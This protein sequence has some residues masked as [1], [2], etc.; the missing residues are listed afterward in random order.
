MSMR[1]I[2]GDSHPAL[3]ERLA[4]EVL[5]RRDERPLAPEWVV[6]PSGALARFLEAEL[7]ARTRKPLL[8]VTVLPLHL[9]AAQA[10]SARAEVPEGDAPG[11]LR[12]ALQRVLEARWGGH[13]VGGL[14]A[15]VAGGASVLSTTLDELLEAGLHDPG[16]LRAFLEEQPGLGEPA[17]TTLGIHA[18]WLEALEHAGLQP[19]AVAR[20][21]MDLRLPAARLHLYGFVRLPRRWADLL[22]RALQAT[23]EL[24]VVRYLAEGPGRFG[25]AWPRHEREAGLAHY[26]LDPERAMRDTSWPVHAAVEPFLALAAPGGRA[27]GEDG[28]VARPAAEGLGGVVELVH[29]RGVEGEVRAAAR[30][31]ARELDDASGG[32]HPER[33]AVLVWDL[34]QYRTTLKRVFGEACIPLRWLGPSPAA[35]HP[36]VQWLAGLLELPSRRLSRSAL[37]ETLGSPLVAGPAAGDGEWK[38]GLERGLADAGVER[39]EAPEARELVERQGQGWSGPLLEFLSDLDAW[40]AAPGAGAWLDAL[41]RLLERWLDPALREGDSPLPGWMGRLEPLRRAD[42]L[43]LAPAAREMRAQAA[44]A[45]QGLTLPSEAPRG[46]AVWVGS[47]ASALGMVFDTVHL[48]GLNHPDVPRVRREQALLPDQARAALRDVLGVPLEVLAEGHDQERWAFAQSMLGARR[49]LV[50]S[51]RGTDRE[52]GEEQASLF[53]PLVFGD[54]AHQLAR[55]A[56]EA[57]SPAALAQG[58]PLGVEEVVAACLPGLAGNPGGLAA[59]LEQ[60]N[61][62]AGGRLG[63]AL[64]C[65]RRRFIER[66]PGPHDLT[67]LDPELAPLTL[68]RSVSA[69]NSLARCPHHFFLQRVLGVEAAPEAEPPWSLPRADVGN[70]AHRLLQLALEEGVPPAGQ[71]AARVARAWREACGEVLRDQAGARLRALLEWDLQRLGAWLVPAAEAEV[72]AVQARRDQL[73]GLEVRTEVEAE[74]TVQVPVHEGQPP[75]AFPLR[76]RVDRLDLAPPVAGSAPTPVRVVDYKVHGQPD[77]WRRDAVSPQIHLYRKVIPGG[78]GVDGEYLVLVPGATPEDLVRKR[79]PGDD[80]DLDRLHDQRLG[81]LA[82]QL[83]ARA[84]PFDDDQACPGCDLAPWCRRFESTARRKS[85][86]LM[87]ALRADLK[88][89]D[90]AILERIP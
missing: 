12:L 41:V 42:A 43:G 5:T 51:W 48:L 76:A 66:R 35:Q 37:A 67:V 83:E 31:V 40:Q 52:G 79:V 68:A 70:L 88:E 75:L 34:D 69:W 27:P 74:G 8:N 28:G 84:F 18:D 15:R 19:A 29:A 17:A 25:D 44:E 9:V 54:L 20:A 2:R 85:R 1:L 55:P 30:D 39:L 56:P 6:V 24:E 26:R 77:G 47:A 32:C 23:P 71:G 46:R 86:P 81:R 3:L 61:P 21:G 4:R 90:R 38:P 16:V 63:A 89:L 22:E 50:L 58:A 87:T 72:A 33:V 80:P 53:L 73:G 57:P 62:G 7:A 60:L 78:G 59:L 36:L 49:R 14:L 13:P 82:R 45:L 10:A 64:D 11:L 65:A